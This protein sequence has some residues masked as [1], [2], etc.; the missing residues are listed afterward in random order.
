MLACSSEDGG[1][2]P[3]WNPGVR[4]NIFGKTGGEGAGLRQRREFL[5]T[6][7]PFAP[8]PLIPS[9]NASLLGFKG[10]LPREAEAKKM[11]AQ[12]E[13]LLQGLLRAGGDPPRVLAS[14]VEVGTPTRAALQH[15]G[16]SV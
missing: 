12:L 11:K 9:P 10:P 8:R 3:A 1:L 7:N 4:E 14:T 16:K 15:S 13:H 6:R 5:C 2:D